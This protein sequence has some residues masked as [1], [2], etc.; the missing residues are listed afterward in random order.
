MIC[1]WKK[2]ITLCV[3]QFIDLTGL[4]CWVKVK[5]NTAYLGSWIVTQV[6]SLVLYR[7]ANRKQS[8]V[9]YHDSLKLGYLLVL[10]MV[11]RQHAI[12]SQVLTL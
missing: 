9:T 2:E 12:G 7:I 8:M 4:L 6:I 11:V 1:A 10:L 3:M 5:K